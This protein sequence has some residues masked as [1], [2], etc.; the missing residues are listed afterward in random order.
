MFISLTHDQVQF[1]YGSLRW[2]YNFNE[3]EELVLLKKKKTYLLI[4]GAFIAVTAL[5]Y[6]CMLFT[7]LMD[8]YYVIP[9]L[10]CYSILIILR[11]HTKIEFEYYVIVK[12]IYQKEIKV[13]IDVMDRPLIGKQIDQ[14]LNHEYYRILHQTKK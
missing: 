4:N 6:Y 2:Q 5:A 8:L 12:D 3:I 10:I 1:H 13:K 9:T 11:L 14:Y 7:D